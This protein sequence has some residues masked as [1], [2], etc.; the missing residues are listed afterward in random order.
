MSYFIETATDRT[1]RR[2]L[3]RGAMFGLAYGDALAGQPAD[4]SPQHATAVTQLA[5]FTTEGLLRA[6][7]RAALKGIGGAETQIVWESY[8][9]WRTTQDSIY[10]PAHYEGSREWPGGWLVAEPALHRPT[11]T[12]PTTWQ[13]LST[14]PPHP[15]SRATNQSMG[16]DSLPRLVPVGLLYFS[17]PEFA[18][19]RAAELAGLTHGHPVAQ[20]GAAW[21][22]AT[23]AYL[24]Q[25][26]PLASAARLAAQHL[27]P[28][29]ATGAIRHALETAQLLLE[30]P[31]HPHLTD[32]W[33]W[34]GQRTAPAVVLAAYYHAQCHV[35]QPETA[36]REAANRGGRQAAALTG[37]LLGAQFGEAAW[38]AGWRVAL[39][40]GRVVVDVADDLHTGLKGSMYTPDEGWWQR[41]P[42]W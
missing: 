11:R 7:H 28:G 19:E 18:A 16:A 8:L 33:H 42:G 2:T 15:P 26:Q 30:N 17:R 5:L 22:A 29:E 10:V 35:E 3:V 6:Y 38:P 25:G 21:V 20:A 14:R 41:Y 31:R 34:M 24:R 23:V 32:F 36:L 1:N 40:L 27:L 37:A 12:G 9:R 13:E 39:D 4:K